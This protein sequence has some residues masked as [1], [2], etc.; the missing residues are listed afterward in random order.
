MAVPSSYTKRGEVTEK[1]I[2]SQARKYTEET[3]KILASTKEDEL[4]GFACS[5]NFIRTTQ[6]VY[7]LENIKTEKRAKKRIKNTEFIEYMRNK[8]RILP[9]GTKILSGKICE[10]ENKTIILMYSIGA[11]DTQSMDSARPNQAILYSYNNTAFVEV[12]AESFF[13]T[14]QQFILAR[15]KNHIRCDQPFQINR[16]Q[17]SL[18]SAKKRQ[19]G[20][21]VI[22]SI[23]WI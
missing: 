11:Y 17:D 4:L 16:N 23:S 18:F 12:L 2:Y 21:Q 15:S 8:E 7:L 10:M 20:L 1:N 22:L 5:D 19:T 6:G 13:S 3:K 9:K 14:E